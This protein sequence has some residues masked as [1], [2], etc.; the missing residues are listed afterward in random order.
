MESVWGGATAAPSFPSWSAA[1]L[2]HPI[3]QPQ[4]L[5]SEPVTKG[6]KTEQE[7]LVSLYCTKYFLK[8]SHIKLL[9]NGYS[10][11]YFSDKNDQD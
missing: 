6:I 1:Q 7:I 5:W 11:V 4:S 3:Q 8:L 10:S 9:P 2:G